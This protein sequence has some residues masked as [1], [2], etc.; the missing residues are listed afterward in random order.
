MY[1]SGLARGPSPTSNAAARHAAGPPPQPSDR[2]CAAPGVHGTAADSACV[3]SA[4]ARGGTFCGSAVA[5]RSASVYDAGS[6]ASIHGTAMDEQEAWT[7]FE[8]WRWPNGPD[9]PHCSALGYAKTGSRLGQLKCADCGKAFRA[10]SGTPLE[11]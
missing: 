2:A 3:Y 4:P 1:R 8:A 7:R 6:G 9:C 5:G 10:T 11:G